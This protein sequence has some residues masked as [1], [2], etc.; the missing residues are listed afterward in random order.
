M[1]WW[2]RA[3]PVASTDL[4]QLRGR[5]GPLRILLAGVGS[6]SP[7]ILAHFGL[8]RQSIE[9]AGGSIGNT[10]EL[11]EKLRRRHRRRRRALDRAGVACL[12]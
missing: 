7:A 6:D 4:A 11:R 8:S 3:P 10:P 1:C 5:P 2:P 12:D 9:A